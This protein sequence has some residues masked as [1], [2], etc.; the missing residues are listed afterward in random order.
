M[1]QRTDD[2]RIRHIRPLLSPAI[3]HEEL[4]LTDTI[5]VSPEYEYGD[6]SSNLPSADYSQNVFSLRLGT[7]F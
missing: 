1:P 6:F 5:F 7:R 3:L 2:L 4:P